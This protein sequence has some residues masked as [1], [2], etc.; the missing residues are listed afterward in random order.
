MDYTLLFAFWGLTT[1]LIC[2]P[3]ADWAY[4]IAAGLRGRGAHAVLGMVVGH[5]AIALAVAL[6]LAAVVASHAWM[7]T[8]ISVVGGLYLLWL[9]TSALQSLLRERMERG[10]PSS[11][12][13]G[14]A[15]GSAPASGGGA[16][17]LGEPT[18]NG[19]A[20]AVTQ[21]VRVLPS[22]RTVTL[23][24][25]SVSLLNPKVY[26]MFLALVPQFVSDSAPLSDGVQLIVLGIVHVVTCGIIY[27]AVSLGAGAV[28]I[29][30]PRAATVVTAASG[31][32]MSVL[33]VAV[34]VELIL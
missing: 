31:I 13:R 19:G 5:F 17:A 12:S 34:I 20:V 4:L 9:G 24:G 16:G 6:G 21:R 28:L 29:S 30:R 27:L 1:L 14:A 15:V 22:K 11:D 33:G 26:L 2:T 18:D 7:L 32:I 3:G 25:L 10:E 23:Q 8:V